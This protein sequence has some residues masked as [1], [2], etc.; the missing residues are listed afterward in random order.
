MLL[1]G[2]PSAPAP[3]TYVPPGRLFAGRKGVGASLPVAG[4]FSL[5]GCLALPRGRHGAAPRRGLRAG[6][7]SEPVCSQMLVRGRIL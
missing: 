3:S 5:D 7:G 1:M 4:C 6:A 2:A